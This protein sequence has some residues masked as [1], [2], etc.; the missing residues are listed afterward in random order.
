MNIHSIGPIFISKLKPM[1]LSPVPWYINITSSSNPD[2]LLLL[3]FDAASSS[4]L[5]RSSRA[6][7]Q[8]CKLDG[9]GSP[10]SFDDFR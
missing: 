10:G 4:L 7:T 8:I 1:R 6:A 9:G 2:L 3:R 5:L